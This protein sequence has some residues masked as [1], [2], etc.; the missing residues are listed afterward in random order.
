MGYYRLVVDQYVDY[1]LTLYVLDTYVMVLS[2]V[3]YF[4]PTTNLCIIRVA[5]EG[6]QVAWGGVTLITA[7]DGVRYIPHL[8]HLSG[9]YCFLLCQD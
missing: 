7:I 3:K 2:A 9:P 8:I 4:S 6:H 5:R 1:Y